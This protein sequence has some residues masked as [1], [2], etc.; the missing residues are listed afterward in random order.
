MPRMSWRHKVDAM[1]RR[2][3]KS[4]RECCVILGGRGGRAAAE[5][6]RRIAADR[7]KQEAMGLA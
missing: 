7:R 2:S 5:K 1:M 4:F 6:K 3:G